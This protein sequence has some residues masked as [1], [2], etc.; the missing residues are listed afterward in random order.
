MFSGLDREHRAY[1]FD[2][3]QYQGR[4]VGGRPGGGTGYRRTAPSLATSAGRRPAAR[5]TARAAP[6]RAPGPQPGRDAAAPALR[7]PGAE[8]ALRPLH[9]RS[10]SSR[11][12]GCRPDAFARVCELVTEN[13]GRDRT[14]ALVYSV[15]WTQHT[16]GV[17]YIRTAAILQTAARQHRPA[18]RRHP[19][20]AR[21]RLHPGLHRHP[22]PVRPAARLPARCRT[23]TRTRTW[24]A[25][26]RRRPCRH[27]LLGQ[28]ARLHGQPAEG[29]VGR[30]RHGG[31]RLLLRL[32]AQADRQPQHLRDRAGADRRATARATSCSARTRPSARPTA[33]CSGSAWPTWTGWWSATSS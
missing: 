23:R 11:S 27:G 12:A 7:V 9:A 14:S 6:T 1:D 17:Q 15:G 4:D 21:P 18:R 30:G 3:W 32:P 10:W 22:H 13:S 33:G 24:P 16:V 5:R 31:E 25:S 19:G 26:C 20:A 29:L 28:H 2:A 8:A